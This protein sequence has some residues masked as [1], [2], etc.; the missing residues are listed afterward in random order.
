MAGRVVWPW[1]QSKK[2]EKAAE[3]RLSARIRRFC[4][5]SGMTHI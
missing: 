2:H 4:C 5:V 1:K 3:S